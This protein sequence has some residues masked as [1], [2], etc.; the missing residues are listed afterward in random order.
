[1]PVAQ[2]IKLRPWMKRLFSY[3]SVQELKQD[4]ISSFWVF[5]APL[6]SK[7][8]IVGA[9]PIGM[10]LMNSFKE[11]KISVEGVFDDAVNKQGMSAD[12]MVIQPV[13]ALLEQ[14]RTI[15][16]V[17]ATQRIL[18]LQRRV[19]DM[20]FQYIWPFFVLSILAPDQFKPHPFYSGMLDDLFHHRNH[21]Q[22]LSLMLEDEESR[23]A[24]DAIIGFRLTLDAKIL[25]DVIV[26]DSYL[27]QEIFNFT[28]QEV[29]VDGGAFDGD[30][31]R[32]FI[33]ICSGRFKKIISFEPSEGPFEILKRMF[34]VDHRI[35]LLQACLHDEE[36]TLF[37]ENS[38]QRD[39]FAIKSGQGGQRVRAM[40]I[41]SLPEAGEVT[42]IKMNIEGAEFDALMGAEKIIRNRQPK[43]AIAVYHRPSDLWALPKLI[44]EFNPTYR[45]YLRQHDGGIIES[46]VYATSHPA[47]DPRPRGRENL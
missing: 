3:K 37:F 40:N 6:P 7:V 12:G 29:F 44:K 42:F 11:N 20:G 30:T 32:S 38:G 1:M 24:L 9:S 47:G 15:P 18:G 21:L 8:L 28:D 5:G 41:D 46:V 39:S 43:L 45:L 16:V 23:T 22:E 17:L 35:K 34:G 33:N 36:T 25:E 27:S 10:K 2:N 14:D 19:E 4:M 13:N 26:P 31:I